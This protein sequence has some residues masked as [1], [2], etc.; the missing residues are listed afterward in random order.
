MKKN[1]KTS[2]FKI[3]LNAFKFDDE[4]KKKE[5]TALLSLTVIQFVCIVLS[6]SIIIYLNPQD[7]AVNTVMLIAPF[8]FTYVI[9]AL[10]AI[11]P[12]EYKDYKNKREEKIFKVVNLLYTFILISF[13]LYFTINKNAGI[14]LGLVTLLIFVTLISVD[15]YYDKSKESTKTIDTNNTH[16]S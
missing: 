1:N 5:N 8:I 15:I 14:I 6:V 10:Y 2:M 7:K 13:Y 3:F 16:T 4:M 9:D 11:I 12:D